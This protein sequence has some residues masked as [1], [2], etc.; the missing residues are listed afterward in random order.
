MTDV[1][2]MPADAGGV[3]IPVDGASYTA[4][5]T[6]DGMQQPTEQ[7]SP[8]QA[9]I[10]RREQ[11]LSPMDKA[12]EAATV[13]ATA[14]LE[15]KEAAE[16][17]AKPEPVKTEPKVEAK[18]EAKEPAPRAQ[19]GKFAPKPETLAQQGQQPAQEPKPTQY[20]DAPARF[21]D[22]AKTEW[23]NAPES[24]KGAVTRAVKELE[25]GITKYKGSHERYEQFKEY[26]ETAKQNGRDLKQSIASVLEFEKT[27]KTNPLAAIDYAL[28]EAG[29]R[30]SQGRPLTLNDIV[31]HV[32]GQSTDQ[33]V[34]QAQTRIQELETQ[35]QQMEYAK[36]VPDMV[37]EF[38]ST[39]D[40]FDELTDVI[41]PLLKSG[42]NL[43]TAY[44]LAAAPKPA[45]DPKPL[46][47]A[48][49]QQA[50]AQTQVQPVAANPAGQK[51]ISGAPSAG[52][53]PAI[54]KPGA[55]NP[56]LDSTLDR[57]FARIGR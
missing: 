12:I 31:E 7:Q 11:A 47:P 38:A 39:H 49:T 5:I 42:H 15:A 9:Q 50:L 22:A 23:A 35:I 48:E 20:K 21:D 28:R 53:D 10:S 17:A 52:S 24:V 36:K 30:D 4:P 46:I 25:E 8:E 32:S 55:K 56:S 40:R 51:S 16:K 29:P 33:R 44:E 43:E 2:A 1:A 26:D 27:I 6:A 41:V 3:E 54:R 34:Q 13:K 45:S 37:A 18:V 14:K 57:V 19:D